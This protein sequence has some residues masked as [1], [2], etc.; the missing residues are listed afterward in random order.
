MKLA[1]I[2][3]R[4]PKGEPARARAELVEL[5]SAAGE[6]GAGLIVC[7]EMATSGYMWA[8]EGEL[9]PHAEP[10]R[11][12]TFAALSPLAARHGAWVVCGF[13]EAA[14]EGGLYNA[15][16]VI[17]PDGRLLACYRKVMLYEADRPWARAGQQRLAFRAPFGV[18]APAICM[19]LNDDGLILALRRLGVDVLAFCTS[20]VEQGLDVHAYWRWRLG[21]WMGWMVAAD[22]WGEDRG[23]RFA[24]RSAI[25][26][27]G[28][29]VLAELGPEGDGVVIA[30]GPEG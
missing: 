28:G 7:P 24:G 17:A 25:L 20:W 4:A 5:V 21:G 15:A 12:P 18:L 13:P 16:L 9:A 8:S 29:V 10:A 23:T 3:Y 1:A 2:Q 30:E 27:P 6:A 14:P 19:D 11:G 26:G 22:N